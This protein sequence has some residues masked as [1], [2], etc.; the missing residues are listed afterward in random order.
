[1]LD[2]KIIFWG[3]GNVAEKF[4]K[5]HKAFMQEV[6]VQG[7]TDSNKNKWGTT[8]EGYEIECP[9]VLLNQNYDYILIL[10]SFFEE[11]RKMLL[12]EYLVFSGKVLSIDEAYAMYAKNFWGGQMINIIMICTHWFRN[13]HF[14]NGCMTEC[15]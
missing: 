3:T 7:F 2:K 6:Q 12:E 1:M 10:S 9:E 15:L 11:I 13:F 4:I 14:R 8:F 5:N